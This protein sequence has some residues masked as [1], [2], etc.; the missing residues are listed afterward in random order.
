MHFPLLHSPAYCTVLCSLLCKSIGKTAASS[1]QTWLL[2]LYPGFLLATPKLE[3]PAFAVNCCYLQKYGSSM[4]FSL[5][6]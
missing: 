2:L 4:D 3:N 1:T 6:C 5:C